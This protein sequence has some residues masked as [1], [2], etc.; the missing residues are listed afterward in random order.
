MAKKE[1]KSR[2]SKAVLS[3]P[4]CITVPIDVAVKCGG[5]YFTEAF[6]LNLNTFLKRYAIDQ[7]DALNLEQK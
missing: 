7:R 6:K 4:I 5:F 3:N 1:K 2:R